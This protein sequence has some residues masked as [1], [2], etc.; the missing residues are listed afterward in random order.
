MTDAI[1]NDILKELA[2]S[3]LDNVENGITTAAA[4]AWAGVAKAL[5]VMLMV[6][7]GLDKLSLGLG[8]DLVTAIVISIAAHF[9]LQQVRKERAKEGYKNYMRNKEM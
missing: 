4:V 7:L 3:S 9:V 2:K 6:K 8:G 5:V 1:A